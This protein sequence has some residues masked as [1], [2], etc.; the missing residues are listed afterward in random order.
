MDAIVVS[1]YVHGYCDRSICSQLERT[2]LE[3]DFE[4]GLVTAWYGQVVVGAIDR[5]G[6]HRGHE[7]DLGVVAGRNLEAPKA[8]RHVDDL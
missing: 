4:P 7:A 5:C 1:R 3:V 2:L 8:F 6:G